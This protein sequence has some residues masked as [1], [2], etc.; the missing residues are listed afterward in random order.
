[1]KATPAR[2]KRRWVTRAAAT[3]LSDQADHRDRV[4]RQPRLDQ[5]V[6]GVGAE[7][8]PVAGLATVAATARGPG[9]RRRFH[10]R[11]ARSIARAREATP[12]P[13]AGEPRPPGPGLGP[14]A[15]QQPVGDQGRRGGD[16]PAERHVDPVVVGGDDH[17]P[18][19]EQRPDR[20]EGFREPVAADHHAGAADHQREGAVH[21]RHRRVGVDEDLRQRGVV[22]D[23]GEV[24]RSCR[25]SRVRGTSAAARSGT[26]CS[27]SAPGPSRRRTCCGRS[28]RTRCGTGRAR[29]GSRARSRTGR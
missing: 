9:G 4:G 6:A 29:S 15:G 28:N 22:V 20:P 23:A 18:G 17:D 24:G 12:R 27:R 8:L 11:E 10:W 16:G 19:D 13:L 2:K 26:A 7:L 14:G 5:P 1:M 25:R 3:R 21:A